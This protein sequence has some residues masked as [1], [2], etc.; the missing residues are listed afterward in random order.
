MK[1]GAVLVTAIA[2]DIG[3][4]TVRSLM[5]TDYR[6]FGCDV[7][8]HSPVSD[9][10]DKAY[11]V[12]PASN[13]RQYL[14]EIK[15]I[16]A[17]HDIS[18]FIPISEPEI[19]VVN[20]N[21]QEFS[22]M[23]VKLLLNDVRILERFLDKYTTSQYLDSIGISVPKT[24]LLDDYHGGW[25]Y[26]LIVKNRSG[27]GSR[28][29]WKIGNEQDLNYVRT[30]CDSSFIVQQHVGDASE[31]YTTGV[32]SNGRKVSSISFRR[33]LGADGTTVEAVLSNESSLVVMAERIAT[34][35]NLVG[36]INI[37]SR[38]VHNAFLP[39]E[40]NPRIS[41]T[42]LFR[43]KFGFDEVIWWIDT[44]FGK[45]YSYTPLYKSGKAIRYYAECYFDMESN[46]LKLHVD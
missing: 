17:D 38:R 41:G 27:W 6:L 35:V 37:Q 19:W 46:L 22:S 34:A 18:V 7:R 42:V 40:I 25:D 1:K 39:F 31:E 12:S 30:K 10:V 4:S 28:T 13:K 26:P 32:F 15:S 2:G 3:Y 9:A 23:G 5:G 44:L 43:K 14:D 11:L 20:E 45:E 21:R 29:I 36:Y 24:V 16:I 8:P 33:R